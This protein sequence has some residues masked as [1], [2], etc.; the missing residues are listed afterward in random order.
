MK[1]EAPSLAMGTGAFSVGECGDLG[2]SAPPA[3]SGLPSLQN[4]LAPLGP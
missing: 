3:A 2:R 4:L 1:Q